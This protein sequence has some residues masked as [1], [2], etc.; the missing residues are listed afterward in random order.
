[1]GSPLSFLKS[2]RIVQRIGTKIVL[3][4]VGTGF[5]VVAGVMGV[6]DLEASR[7]LQQR[8]TDWALTETRRQSVRFDRIIEGARPLT[9]AIA[10]YQQFRPLRA[11]QSDTRFYAAL[12]NNSPKEVVFGVY[13]TPDAVH[14]NDPACGTYVTQTSYPNRV[15]DTYDHLAE[16]QLWYGVPKRTQ[17]PYIAGAYYDDSV[18]ATM[19]SYTRP[20]HNAAGQFIG[21]AGV[22]IG[23]NQVLSEAKAMKLRLPSGRPED[24]F[25]V[26]VDAD[27]NI[28][29]HP[30]TKFLVGKDVESTPF[31]KTPEGKVVGSRPEGYA[32]YT[33][34]GRRTRLF[35]TTSSLTGWRTFISVPEAD[36]TAAIVQQRKHMLGVA[37]LGLVVLGAIVTGVSRRIVRP[38]A[39]VTAAAQRVADGDTAVA[40]THQSRDESG[41]LADAFRQVIA[42]Q[43]GLAE[44]A[45]RLAE[46]DLT[47][48]ITPRCDRDTLG[49]SM[50]AL[51]TQW[52]GDVQH[53]DDRSERLRES[54]TTLDAALG[55]AR[56]AA[57]QMSLTLANMAEAGDSAAQTSQH[58]AAGSEQL[59][60]TA[61]EAAQAMDELGAVVSQ[62]S[63]AG[64]TQQAVAAEASRRANA[65]RAAF[66]GIQSAMDLIQQEVDASAA[67][68]QALGRRQSEIGEIVATIDDISSQTNLLALN[69]AI[70]A[71]RAGEQGRG[72]AVV[73]DEVRKLAERAAAST[74]QIE[75]LIDQV[76]AEVDA[77]IAGMANSREAVARGAAGTQ[78]GRE[79]LEAIALA[80]ERVAAEAATN[81]AS[82]SVMSNQ[83]LVVNEAIAEVASVSQETA[84][85]A[86]EMTAGIQELAAGMQQTVA[87]VAR[88]DAELDRIAD[89]ARAQRSVADE[90]REQ[91][92]HFRVDG[93]PAERSET[94]ADDRP[95]PRAA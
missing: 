44:A 31:A 13:F 14:W 41:E 68:V 94:S 18:Q 81:Q 79:A 73:A 40:L 85:G 95:T 86:E 23:I 30:N 45:S 92:A 9:N 3:V 67:S 84:A 87:E 61:Q 55:Q 49:Q 90:L 28:I 77:A 59:A 35:W 80:V 78:E 12:L 20:V 56:G 48:A 74:Q 37:I 24:Q 34:Q 38:L 50:A 46:G 88:Q 91:I 65:G 22:D 71:A 25:A 15:T 27:G 19:V 11:D 76:K 62:V 70:E 32:L 36:L 5:F 83:T 54:A 69:A 52:S 47:V 51:V 72:F 75:T 42:H 64:E 82:L 21:V 26:V 1:M 43:R 8:T 7:N 89:E 16:D 60:R 6:A 10:T 2:S 29:A 63:T 17:K 93:P 33:H 66:D 53:L 39:Q 58:I 4:T 57:I